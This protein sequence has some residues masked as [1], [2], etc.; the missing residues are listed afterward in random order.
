MEKIDYLYE[1]KINP[2]SQKWYCVSFFSKKYVKKAIDNNND[3]LEEL[4]EKY[5]YS[6]TE[7]KKDDYS[8]DDDVLA[9]K[10]RGGFDTY[11]KACNHASALRNID[12]HHHIYVVEAGKWCAF[13]T[14]D[15]D[16]FVEQT[17]HANDELNSM[18]KKYNENQDKAKIY[19]EFRKNVMVKESLNENI[20]NKQNAFNLTLDLLKQ[21][22]DKEQIE[23]LRQK[24]N[25]LDEQISKLQERKNEIEKTCAEFE[26]KLKLGKSQTF[27]TEL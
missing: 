2:P 12:Q 1:D 14:E 10:I 7:N 18:M 23:K 22:E 5:N 19:H 20:E 4:K 27:D 16:D 13:K 8:V 3:T 6:Q 11:D 15:N 25:T 21:T 26:E 9:F 17:E 24:R